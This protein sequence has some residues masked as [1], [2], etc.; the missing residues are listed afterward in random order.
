MSEYFPHDY[1]A[2]NDEKILDLRDEL[3]N[4]GYGLYWMIVE[5]IHEYGGAGVP[6]KRLGWIARECGASVED[7]ER[8]IYSFDLFDV[9]NDRV[10]SPR[11]RRN[12]VKRKETHERFEKLS[13][14]AVEARKNKN[15][16]P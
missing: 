3:G 4:A 6:T 9:Q 13:K 14:I 11:I 5:C 12:I 1:N 10:S 15:N 16:Q 2:R 8:I 7:V